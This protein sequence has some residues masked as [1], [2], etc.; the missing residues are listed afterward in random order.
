METP[1]YFSFDNA[2]G[3]CE[4]TETMDAMVENFVEME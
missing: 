4:S 1:G 3:M 2:T